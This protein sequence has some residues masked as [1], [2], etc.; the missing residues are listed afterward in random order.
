MKNHKSYTMRF[1]LVV[2]LISGIFGVRPAQ[3]E[4]VDFGWVQGGGG[5]NLDYG[6]AIALDDGGNV[7]TTG[8][9]TNG[10]GNQDGF[11]QK[12]D[13]SGNPIWA[14]FVAGPGNDTNHGVALDGNENV[15]AAGAYSDTVEFNPGN[16]A[17]DLTSEG[18]TD[19]FV[20]KYDGDGNFIWVKSVGGASSDGGY[21]I[22]TDVSGNIYLTGIYVDTVD[23]DPGADVSTLTSAGFADVFVLKLDSDG[24]FLWAK[25]MGGPGS[26]YGFDVAV[27]SSG[28]VFTTGYFSDTA[29]FDPGIGMSNLTSLGQG[30]LFISKLDSDGDF[31]WAQRMGAESFDAGIKIAVDGL[32]NLYTVGYLDVGR[33][34]DIFL[35][36]LDGDGNVLWAHVVGGESYDTGYGLALDDSGNVYYTG[37]FSSTVD[38]DPGAGTS[39]LTSTGDS[40]IFISKLDSDGNFVWAKNLG[41]AS[42]DSGDGIAVQNDDS[43]YF[44]GTFS[45][46]VDFDLA[47]GTSTLTSAGSLDVFIARLNL[48]PQIHYVKWDANGS[49]D[50]S[51]W[52][53]AYTD[54]QSALAAASNGDEIWVAAGVYKPTSM[55][56]RTISFTLKN[57]VAVYGGFVGTETERDH[58]D[59]ETNVAVLSGDIGVEGDTSDNSYHV[60]VASDTNHSAILDGFT[61][62][63]GNANDLA[64]SQ[65]Y[66]GGGMYI[67]KG[68][69]QLNGLIF[70]DN[71][72]GFGG[73]IYASHTEGGNITI[74][75]TLTNV[76]F[77]D[78][79]AFGEGG[80]M[81]TRFF[82]DL[83]SASFRLSLT[84]VI[85]ENN[86]AVRTGGGMINNGGEL[87][88]VNVNFSGNTAAGG[89]GLSNIP[90][91][92]STLTNVTFR[93]NSASDGGGGM[94]IG[95]SGPVLS[96]L[97]NVTFSNNSTDMS[98]GGIANAYYSDLLLTNVTFSDN[99]AGMNGG[100]ITNGG[101]F[102]IATGGTIDLINTTFS[103]NAAN[104]NG[105][106]IYNESGNI[107]I[108]NSILY[109]DIGGEIANTSGTAV[110]TYSIVQGGYTGVG[111]L[112]ED[113][114]LGPLQ[115][116]G[117][118]TQTM[119][120]GAGSPAIDAGDNTSCPLT[121][122]RGV[123]R[124]QRSH[125]DIGAYEYDGLDSTVD[126]IIGS[127]EVDSY[128]LS[129]HESQRRSYIGL[130]DGPVKVVNT[131]DFSILAA[132]RV[133]YKVKGVQTSFSEMM[134]LPDNQL[135]K[136]Y[137]F[138]WYNNVGLDTQLRIANATNSPATVQV[139]IDGIAMTP[140]NLAAGESTRVSYPGVNSGPVKIESDQDIVVA[141]R[142]IY[143][144]NSIHTSFSEMIALP[145]SQL[146][147]VYWLP[148]YNNVDLDTQLR[149][150]NVTDQQ[151]TITVTMGGVQQTPFNLAAGES[152]RVSYPGANNGPVK[153]E[154]TQNIVAAERVIYKVKG[155]QTSFSEM[156]AL[157]DSQLDTVYWLPWYNNVDLDTQLRFGNVSDQ[158]ATVRVYIGGQE[159]VGSPFTLQQGESTRQ[160]FPNIN[161]GPMKIT[162]NVPIVVAE[163]VIYKVKGI[164]TSFSEMMVLPNALLDATFWF[165]WYNNVDLDTQLRFGVP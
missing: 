27:D 114:L 14:K 139:T 129:P 65:Y 141:E 17:Y 10:P 93:D 83:S 63:A 30:D 162:S 132:E 145:N 159:M 108:H 111:N 107:N 117:G 85:F 61:I 105:A 110:V 72:A 118:F 59:Y 9:V 42:A 156:M 18:L 28:N 144:V 26:D 12:W 112:D 49:N 160:S 50:G 148:W 134:G 23:F 35:G 124:P 130:N 96:T 104:V 62:T 53:N 149:I 152:T 38:F 98:G 33:S 5:T 157:P 131:D 155:I 31:V 163:R 153:I 165:P 15:Y 70:T 57:G 133:I 39:N 36:K 115:D 8:F 128:V 81:A 29:D 71:H 6:T 88:L 91:G 32:G 151:A 100:G 2:V 158:T 99:T 120:L 113:P 77:K 55:T 76:V 56:D 121:D 78:N 64:S 1:A 143:K 102:D 51:S 75:L 89:G 147:S 68:S 11:L 150:A 119:A 13:T 146:D 86:T 103:N 138:P 92:S 101:F 44:I 66:Y 125:C 137:W 4:T 154:S 109:G 67:N 54:L 37:D 106:A 97:T 46:T 7:Y 3:A 122:Q 25:S 47:A 43:L 136:T 60:V 74:E 58:R 34:H 116:N 40:D 164:E 45:D 41:G 19:I 95:S 22:T 87:E 94:L 52:T 140:L 127:S 142:A 24:N 84:D 20:I 90:Y 21:G 79:T 73:G 69:P 16:S 80:G 161:N 123:T 48:T 126:V 82:P 135:D